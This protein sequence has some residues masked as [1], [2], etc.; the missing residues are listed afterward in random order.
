MASKCRVQGPS[1]VL[2]DVLDSL[3]RHCSTAID[4]ARLP[5]YEPSEGVSCCLQR[6]RPLPVLSAE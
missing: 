6:L 5:A 3:G 4:G 2:H 1:W